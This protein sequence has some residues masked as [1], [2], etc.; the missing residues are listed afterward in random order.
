[1]VLFVCLFLLSFNVYLVYGVSKVKDVK[2]R[3]VFVVSLIIH[4]FFFFLGGGIAEDIGYTIKLVSSG[5]E[6][7]LAYYMINVYP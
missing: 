1:M 5:R 4:V 6:V 2:G 7:Q 3:I